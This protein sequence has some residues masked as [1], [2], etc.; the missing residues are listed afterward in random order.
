MRSVRGHETFVGCGTA[1]LGELTPRESSS[2]PAADVLQ[3]GVRPLEASPRR[4]GDE[5]Y[6]DERDP[7]QV[8]NL[9]ALPVE[10]GFVRVWTRAEWAFTTARA[11]LA[12]G[13]LAGHRVLC[14]PHRRGRP[15]GVP[16]LEAASPNAEAT[17]SLREGE[18][19]R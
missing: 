3:L 13:L 1:A 18:A 17:G 5:L 11:T 16:L 15:A 14:A 7:D 4:P 2:T 9:G 19:S 10:A 6:D 12:L 8:R